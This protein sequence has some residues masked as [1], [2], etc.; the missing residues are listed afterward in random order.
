[1]RPS[2]YHFNPVHECGKL[3][4]QKKLCDV[5]ISVIEKKLYGNKVS[6]VLKMK[7]GKTE[8]T[9]SVR[10]MRHSGVEENNF[11]ICLEHY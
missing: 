2:R 1:M 10:T 7:T 4:E 6:Q 5:D 8:Q 9:W 3:S 11:H